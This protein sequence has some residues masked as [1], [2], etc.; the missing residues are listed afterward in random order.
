M[1]GLLTFA[2]GP[3]EDDPTAG[4]DAASDGGDTEDGDTEETANEDAGAD[5][6]GDETG[7]NNEGPLPQTRGVDVLVVIDN[8]RDM[9]AAQGKL[10]RALPR[11][12]EALYLSDV[13]YRIGFTTTDN[14]NP[15]CYSSAEAGNLQL[16]SCR[17]RRSEFVFDG[18]PVVDAFEDACAS[19]CEFGKISV[20]GGPWIDVVDG[21]SNLENVSVGEAIRCF[22]P[23]GIA[24]CGFEQPLQTA[25][26]AILRSQFDGSDSFG[27]HDPARLLAVLFVSNEADCSHVGSRSEIFLP[28]G[29]RVFWSD[30]LLEGPTSAVCWNAGVACSGDGPSY[31]DCIPANYGI[32]GEEVDD[33]EAVV[34]PVSFFTAAFQEDPTYVA[35]ILGVGSD[36]AAVYHDSPDEEFQIDFGIG[37]GCSSGSE[38]GL[39]PVRMRQVISEVSGAGKHMHSIC[40][41][42]YRDAIDSFANNI[43]DRLPD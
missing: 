10:A 18:D 6:A 9:G 27:F 5:P 20:R 25:H 24:G 4:T 43:L 17:S 31:A 42:D 7:P 28:E 29:N 37:P 16:T 22:T 2:C 39:P 14:G 21:Q 1:V 15:W 40:D 34:H 13:D 12:G 26:K 3:N 23:Q 36:G 11:L 32:N 8:S 41:P 30:P 35:G 33:G 38:W 19:V